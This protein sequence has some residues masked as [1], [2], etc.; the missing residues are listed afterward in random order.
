MISSVALPRLNICVLGEVNGYKKYCLIL[1]RFNFVTCRAMLKSLSDCRRVD[2][3]LFLLCPI[4]FPSIIL[5]PT[6]YS[7]STYA[8]IAP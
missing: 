6:I 5:F 7:N 1:I 3:F 4:C 8:S 2:H